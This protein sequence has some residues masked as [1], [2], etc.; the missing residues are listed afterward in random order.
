M[1][2]LSRSGLMILAGIDENADI[3][4]QKYCISNLGR[5]VDQFALSFEDEEHWS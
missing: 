1:H 2:G 5:A 3:N 4:E